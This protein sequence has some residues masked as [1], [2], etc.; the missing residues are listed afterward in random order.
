LCFDQNEFE[1]ALQ[2]NKACLEETEESMLANYKQFK[3]IKEMYLYI[4]SKGKRIP[5]NLREL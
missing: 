2:Y 5:S 1:K 4:R 3:T